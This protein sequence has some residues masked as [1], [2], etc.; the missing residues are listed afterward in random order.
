VR[1][2]V[3]I[4]A[5]CA[6]S[7]AGLGLGALR[8]RSEWAALWHSWQF[9]ILVVF[10]LVCVVIAGASLYTSFYQ[11]F[12]PQG[13][14]LFPALVPISVLLVLGLGQIPTRSWGRRLIWLVAGFW[15]VLLQGASFYL[16]LILRIARHV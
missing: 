5:F 14:Y 12:Q 10:T 11:D 2:Y 8:R 6:A 13:R 7:A 16:Y 15:M 9:R 3:V 1:Y 4:L